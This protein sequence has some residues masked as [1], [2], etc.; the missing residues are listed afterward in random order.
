[1][2]WHLILF[3]RTM[4]SHPALDRTHLTHSR[5]CRQCW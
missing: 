4:G 3:V 2:N 5:Q 1:M